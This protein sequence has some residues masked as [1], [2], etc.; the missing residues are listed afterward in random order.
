MRAKVSEL[1]LTLSAREEA[2]R[3]SKANAECMQRLLDEHEHDVKVL[4]AEQEERKRQIEALSMGSD[5]VDKLLKENRTK[6]GVLASQQVKVN[7]L[8]KELSLKDARLKH[9]TSQISELTLRVTTLERQLSGGQKDYVDQLVLLHQT[10]NSILTQLMEELECRESVLQGTQELLTVYKNK[11]GAGTNDTYTPEPLEASAPVN[12]DVQTSQVMESGVVEEMMAEIMA[13]RSETRALRMRQ[14]ELAS[15]LRNADAEKD[16]LRDRLSELGEIRESYTVNHK[17]EEKNMELQDLADELNNCEHVLSQREAL[18][19]TLQLKLV[20]IPPSENEK[21]RIQCLESDIDEL[22]VANNKTHAENL[23]SKNR[24]ASMTDS[25]VKLESQL[26]SKSKTIDLLRQLLEEKNEAVMLMKQ[27][28]ELEGAGTRDKDVDLLQFLEAHDQS[29]KVLE[30]HTGKELK[31]MEWSVRDLEET[32]REKELVILDLQKTRQLN[33]QEIADLKTEFLRVTRDLEAEKKKRREQ[34]H[35]MIRFTGTI[36]AAHKNIDELRQQLDER[37]DELIISERTTKRIEELARQNGIEDVDTIKSELKEKGKKLRSLEKENEE[38]TKMLQDQQDAITEL[39]Q[40]IRTQQTTQAGIAENLEEKTSEL[41]ELQDIYQ[42]ALAKMGGI[43][44]DLQEMTYDRDAQQHLARDLEKKAHLWEELST[45][46]TN[47]SELAK[48]ALDEKVGAIDL[49][50]DTVE[51]L[52]ERLDESGF[53]AKQRDASS[54]RHQQGFIEL[55][56]MYNTLQADL[57]RREGMIQDFEEELSQADERINLLD[58]HKQKLEEELTRQ[59]QNVRSFE[60]VNEELRSRLREQAHHGPSSDS[61]EHEGLSAVRKISEALQQEQH[62]A[63]ELRGERDELLVKLLAKDTQLA[64]LRKDIESQKKLESISIR[65]TSD[66]GERERFGVLKERV[67]EL[68]ATKDD[69][70]NEKDAM[71][72]EVKELKRAAAKAVEDENELKSVLKRAVQKHHAFVGPSHSPLAM[73][74][75]LV[76]AAAADS[77]VTDLVEPIRSLTVVLGVQNDLDLGE[78]DGLAHAVNVASSAASELQKD[79]EDL[80]DTL[81]RLQNSLLKEK[82]KR[83]LMVDDVQKSKMG[84]EQL[85]K[86]CK[87]IKDM[88]D[89]KL[90]E[91]SDRVIS[92]SDTYPKLE[93]VATKIVTLMQDVRG[94]VTAVVEGAMP[95]HGHEY[96]V[97]PAAVPSTPLPTKKKR[98]SGQKSHRGSLQR[99]SLQRHSLQKGTL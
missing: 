80:R 13:L 78:Q 16:A 49:L 38:C 32:V 89:R 95:D 36:N 41:A 98:G 61:T 77:K 91:A 82:E 94:F 69:I 22:Q 25:L 86:N 92:I 35:D 64:T 44:A 48:Q 51:E 7:T 9:A 5:V 29:L 66:D 4:R 42:E 56:R 34:E 67:M 74:R 24:I 65:S 17:V 40:T 54:S 68:E 43:E 15:S 26:D 6:A 18:I 96:G 99:G 58:T 12:G 70:L 28:L 72:I 60:E 62:T 45:E 27:E 30:A 23:T 14:R 63:D 21:E 55:Q 50:K 83:K 10:K 31:G 84:V 73:A 2:A 3:H 11:T 75:S 52:Q 53:V 87:E 81:E 46:H 19:E 93:D 85:T 1:E 59:L 47:T 90:D 76:T 8:T 79:M 57:K 88:S 37:E 39:K 33:S 71:D 20:T 97:L